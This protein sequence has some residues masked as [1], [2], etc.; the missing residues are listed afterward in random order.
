MSDTKD[1]ELNSSPTA[2][3]TIPARIELGRQTL[4]DANGAIVP[5]PRDTDWDDLNIL[6]NSYDRTLVA[7]WLNAG[8][9]ITKH[10]YRSSEGDV[11]FAVIRA[12][13]VDKRKDFRPLRSQGTIGILPK[14]VLQ[15]IEGKRPLYNLDKLIAR[16]N[17]PVLIV[18]GE[19]TA[20]AAEVRFATHVCTTWPGGAQSVGKAELLP[21][22]G[23]DVTIC[24][25]NDPDGVKAAKRLAIELLRMGVAACRIVELPDGLRPKWDLADADEPECI[26]DEGQIKGLVIDAP[27][28]E[29]AMLQPAARPL[30]GTGERTVFNGDLVRDEAMLRFL[31]DN[32]SLDLGN[33]SEWINLGLAL[34]A[35]RGDVGFALW[36]QLSSE[37]VGYDGSTERVWATFKEPTD[38]QKALTLATYAL[39]ARE[40][41]WAPVPLSTG[42]GSGA[43]KSTRD[44]APA[45]DEA[46]ARFGKGVDPAAAVIALA[47]EAGDEFWI[48]QDGKAH[49]SYQAPDPNGATV[50]RH[51]PLQSA[52]YRAVLSA[53]YFE[54]MVTK[55]LQKDQAQNAAAILEFRARASGVRHVSCLRV[56]ELEGIIYVDLGRLDGLA[57]E[58][59]KDGWS[60][61]ANPPVRFIPGSR[62]EL[63]IPQPGGSIEQFAKHFNLPSDDV[64]RAVAFMI[65]TFNL[66]G[67]Y[68]ILFIEGEQGTCKSTLADLILALTDPPKG[69]KSARFSFSPD[70]KDLHVSAQGA[71]V[72]CFDNISN[73]KAPAADALCRI[74]TGAASTSRKLYTDDEEAR[75]V[76]QRPVMATCIGLPSSRADLL[77]RAVRIKTLPVVRRRTEAAVMR[78]FEEDRPQMVGF[79]MDCVSR[80]LQNRDAIEEAADAGEIQLPRMGDFGLFVEAASPKLGLDR[81]EFSN[82]IRHEQ[83]VMQA[84]AAQTNSV[85]AALMQYF[86]K[87]GAKPINGP[88]RDVLALLQAQLPPQDWWPSVNKLGN[89]LTRIAVGLRELGIEMK[90]DPPSGRENVMMFRICTTAKFRPLSEGPDACDDP[91]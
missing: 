17:D 2:T 4:S 32:G 20:D 9:K 56:A 16:P 22:M 23:R 54:A 61:I 83:A 37:A 87:E 89:E 90:I 25:D 73:F 62:G 59:T 88:A 30:S 15:H 18:E 28:A 34:K 85:G 57:I 80:A 43:T 26:L 19:K 39:N 51:L 82:L 72:L 3:L 78:G 31:I 27:A 6:A 47:E 41:G 53:R 8:A 35:T 66:A 29:S 91:F 5:F 63:P 21:L 84:E 44:G 69:A 76:V 33:R 71:R 50:M 42:V 13:H 38:D 81:G 55:V 48:D 65:G 58:V 7:G 14:A 46:K 49:V 75:L 11:I 77:S 64:L 10:F 70:E 86:S 52:G 1:E 74:A 36:D 45:F 24:P 60:V 68:P 67:S 79:L 12:D 40:A